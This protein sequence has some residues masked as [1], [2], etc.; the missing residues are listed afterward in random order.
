MNIMLVVLGW[1]ACGFIAHGIAFAN[2]QA[3]CAKSV[4]KDCRRGLAYSL[5]THL[6]LGIAGLVFIY[7]FCPK[8]NGFKP[9]HGLKIWA[10]VPAADKTSR[11]RRDPMPRMATGRNGAAIGGKVAIKWKEGALHV[12]Q[13]G[14]D[15]NADTT[16]CDAGFIQ[17]RTGQDA[18]LMAIS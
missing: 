17:I 11:Y 8:I 16:G 15:H 10:S 1:M 6:C 14:G 9:R 2:A 7:L 3:A 13:E 5:L 12:E 18:F 4:K